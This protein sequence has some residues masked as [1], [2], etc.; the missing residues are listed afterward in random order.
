[1]L[2]YARRR[3]GLTQTELAHRAGVPHSTVARIELGR[4]SP[5]VDTL[6]N[7]LRECG[8]ELEAVP[9]LGRGLDRSLIREYVRASPRE[10]VEMVVA[11]AAASRTSEDE[12]V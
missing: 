8:F 1:M 2:R 10:R 11:D 12:F 5:R 9:R 7:L 6:G 4:T 3:A